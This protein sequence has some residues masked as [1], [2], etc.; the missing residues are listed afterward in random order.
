[1]STTATP[2]PAPDLGE[3]LRAI[4]RHLTGFGHS[5]AARQALGAVLADDLDTARTTLERLPASYLDQLGPAAD[6][7]GELA[8]LVASLE[9][10]T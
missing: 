3:T 5:M 9:D 2:P 7:L 10:R 6:R 1:M 8:R 4:G